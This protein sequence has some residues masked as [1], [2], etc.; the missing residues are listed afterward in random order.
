M[1]HVRDLSRTAGARRIPRDHVARLAR[2][3]D[4]VPKLPWVIPT[5]PARPPCFFSED[6]DKVIPIESKTDG[7]HV[8]VYRSNRLR[9]LERAACLKIPSDAVPDDRRCLPDS[10]VNIADF[11]KLRI[12]TGDM[13]D[14]KLP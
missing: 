13:V 5:G 7:H 9:R 3:R 1:P 4:P 14:S 10:G 12:A 11:K 6:C 2:C 8:A